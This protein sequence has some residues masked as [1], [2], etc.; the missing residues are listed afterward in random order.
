MNKHHASTPIKKPM[1]ANS[2]LF[3]M[4]YLAPMNELVTSKFLIREFIASF[5]PYYVV[6]DVSRKM[7]VE[8]TYLRSHLEV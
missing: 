6:T 1:S 4:V 8:A 2:L 7:S 3:N 5:N